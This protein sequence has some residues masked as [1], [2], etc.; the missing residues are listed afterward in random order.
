VKNVI[1]ILIVIVFFGCGETKK[2]NIYE[3]KII[4]SKQLVKKDSLVFY[5]K[6]DR[7]VGEARYLICFRDNILISDL[8]KKCIWVFDKQLN[9]IKMI[10]KEGRGPGEYTYPPKLINDND[11]RLFAGDKKFLDEYDSNFTFIGRKYLPA[12]LEYS[13]IDPIY[14]NGRFIFNVSYPFSIVENEYYRKYKPLVAIDKENLTVKKSF[15]FW[16]DNYFKEDIKAYTRN[17][18]DVLLAKKDTNSFFVLQRGSQNIK[19]YDKSYILLKTFG[20]KQKYFKNP[21]KVK[22]MDTQRNVESLADFMGKIT[23]YMKIDYDKTTRYF[24]LAYTNLESNYY[25][26]RSFDFGK[27]FIQVYNED[28]DVVFDGNIDGRLVF[29]EAN[30]IYTLSKMEDKL[31]KINIYE[32]S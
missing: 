28:Y 25:L 12:K 24:Y 18:F 5:Y 31:L 29:V 22:L 7:F 2:N 23:F 16:D 21:P 6:G 26:N 17:N 8:Y 10:G 15:D 3:S 19:L 11:T 4:N 30:K 13:N 27:Q 32:L 14:I 20:R 9:F 1:H